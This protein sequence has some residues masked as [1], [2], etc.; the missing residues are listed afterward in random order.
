MMKKTVV[1]ASMFALLLSACLPGLSSPTPGT[2]ITVDATGTADALFQTAVV[3]TLTAQPTLPPLSVTDTATVP[4]AVASVTLPPTDILLSDTPIAATATATV[5]SNLTTT[6]VTATSGAAIATAT[7]TL[8]AGQPT[9]TWTPGVRT[10][11]TLPPAVPSNR[12]TV[13]NKAHAD[14][15]ISLHVDMPEGNSVLEYPVEGMIRI[16]APVG[17]YRYVAWVGG[18]KMIGSFR[19]T[20]LD[21]I[22]ITLYK[23]H[24]VIK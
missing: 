12:I 6:P 4:V 23:D 9:P 13:I 11:G 2:G 5:L 14:A 16:K 21:D 10:Y 20:A 24:V 17:F 22:S 15:Y 1:L 8:G 7:A 3:Q 19:L 18:R